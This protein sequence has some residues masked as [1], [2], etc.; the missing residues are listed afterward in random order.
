MKSWRKNFNKNNN[1]FTKLLEQ[2]QWQDVNSVSE[3]N[4]KF[5]WFISKLTFLF[6]KAFPLG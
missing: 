5:E 2:V 4:T 6:N 3:A 1:K